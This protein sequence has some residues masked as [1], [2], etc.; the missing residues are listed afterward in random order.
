MQQYL[1]RRVGLAFLALFAL[2]ILTFLLVRSEGYE[3]HH[4]YGDGG[5][6]YYE[7]PSLVVQ[8][9]RYMNDLFQ[10]NWDKAWGLERGSGQYSL[11][12]TSHHL[13]VSLAC[14]GRKCCPGHNPWGSSS[15]Q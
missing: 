4:Y 5:W 8:Y 13:A 3:V 1:F 14:A 15:H 2:S 6:D 7:K 11:G 10:G 12:T 9:A